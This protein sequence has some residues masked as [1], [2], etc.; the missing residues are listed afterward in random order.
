ME[1]SRDFL[2]LKNAKARL[3]DL[4]LNARFDSSSPYLPTL[5]TELPVYFVLI[6]HS[7]SIRRHTDTICGHPDAQQSV[8]CAS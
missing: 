2:Q 8:Q 7:I 4:P 3:G 5:P 1:K 6:S